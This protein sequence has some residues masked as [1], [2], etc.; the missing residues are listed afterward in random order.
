MVINCLNVIFQQHF[1]ENIPHPELYK[2][3]LTLEMFYYLFVSHHPL[4][5]QIFPILCEGNSRNIALFSSP[6]ITNTFFLR[7]VTFTT[8]NGTQ[9]ET[10]EGN[11]GTNLWFLSY[12]IP[13]ASGV[14]WHN[15]CRTPLLPL[16]EG[17]KWGSGVVFCSGL[18]LEGGGTGQKAPRVNTI[19]ARGGCVQTKSE[20]PRY[21]LAP[22]RRQSH[23]KMATRP[24][25]LLCV[26]EGRGWRK[27]NFREPSDMISETD[28][29]GRTLF[30]LGQLPQTSLI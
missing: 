19:P 5:Q 17:K 22:T 25:Y 24:G 10:F 8:D 16:L 29:R 15:W 14:P 20:N 7:P 18:V 11:R 13:K 3:S 12:S 26:R 27:Q 1:C 2:Q 23:S 9:F 21:L 6:H 4:K 30:L 28:E